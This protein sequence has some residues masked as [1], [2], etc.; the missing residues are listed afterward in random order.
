MNGRR[1]IFLSIAALGGSLV[2]SACGTQLPEARPNFG[3]SGLTGQEA[4]RSSYE[5]GRFDFTA[6]RYGLAIERFQM[7]IAENPASIEAVNGLAASYD[8]IGR[9]DLAERYYRRALAMDP[10]SAQ[11]LNNLGYSMLLQGKTDL[12]LALFRDATRQSPDNPMIAANAQLAVDAGVE[13]EAEQVSE[14]TSA[15]PQEAAVR[16]PPAPRPSIVRITTAEQRLRLRAAPAAPATLLLPPEVTAVP[17]P[18]VET[19]PL[20]PLPAPGGQVTEAP[21]AVTLPVVRVALQTSGADVTLA[22]GPSE[23]P[24]LPDARDLSGAVEVA[25]GTGRRHMAARIKA[26]LLGEGLSVTRLSNADNFNH[27]STSITY[28][29]GYRELAEVLSASLPI[30]PRLQQSTGQATEVRVELGGDLLQFDS[31]LLQAERNTSH[32][33]PV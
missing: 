10:N 19:Q 14:A 32:A 29:P 33:D 15:P 24:A 26:F 8:Q 28:L 20:A 2:V 4:S 9:F 16:Q 31:D 17:L 3:Y 22:A 18:V 7:A 1:G 12:A 23:E 21:V 5:Q 13:N 11:T 25:N 27:S 6:G 30:V